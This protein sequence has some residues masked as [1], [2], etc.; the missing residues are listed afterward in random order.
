MMLLV[1]NMYRMLQ[2]NVYQLKSVPAAIY[3]DACPDKSRVSD[4]GKIQVHS[5]PG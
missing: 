3:G 5:V 4:H 1:E 2:M